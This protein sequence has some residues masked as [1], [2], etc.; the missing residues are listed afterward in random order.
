[1]N[2]L[3]PSRSKLKTTLKGLEEHPVVTGG[4]IALVIAFAGPVLTLWLTDAGPFATPSRQERFVLDA[5]RSCSPLVS[6]FMFDAPG[7]TAFSAEL[8]VPLNYALLGPSDQLTGEP[9]PPPPPR[10]FDG[11]VG[12]DYRP[13][14]G[15]PLK[16]DATQA[17]Q[18]F[19]STHPVGRQLH[20]FHAYR[21]FLLDVGR[22][23]GRTPRTEHDSRL[24]YRELHTLGSRFQGIARRALR[25]E[26]VAL[27]LG[28]DRCVDLARGVKR[29]AMFLEARAQHAFK[30][31]FGRLG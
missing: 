4:V 15:M 27:G 26:D 10:T 25:A 8:N 28:A 2:S 24:S 6:S 14:A 19:E 13:W 20:A 1:M 31:R 29:T 30:R 11:T 5:N 18:A 16:V 9:P 12:S 3:P 7:Q 23:A 17:L 22:H 21:R